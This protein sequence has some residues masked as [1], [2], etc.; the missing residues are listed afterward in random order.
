MLLNNNNL[1]QNVYFEPDGASSNAKVETP[2]EVKPEAPKPPEKDYTD[3]NVRSEV[4][5]RANAKI[6]ELEK[7]ND[8]DSK[9]H[10]QGLRANVNFLIEDIREMGDV[11]S[12]GSRLDRR[13]QM[14]EAAH[15]KI[16]ATNVITVPETVI[17]V[18]A[19]GAKPKPGNSDKD[20]A[21]LQAAGAEKDAA[22]RAALNALPKFQGP[23]NPS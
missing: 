6:A 7:Q 5:A 21:A 9:A 3:P 2:V 20:W 23:D 13:I 4:I 11:Q 17:T 14:V 22:D 18:P 12:S 19:P 16:A 1:P 10:A 8:P 15:N